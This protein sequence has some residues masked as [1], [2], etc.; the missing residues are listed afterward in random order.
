MSMRIT[1]SLDYQPA[2]ASMHSFF[3]RLMNVEYLNRKL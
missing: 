1:A 2:R 3:Y